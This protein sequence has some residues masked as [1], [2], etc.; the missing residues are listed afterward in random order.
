MFKVLKLSLESIKI[1]LSSDIKPQVTASSASLALTVTLPSDYETCVRTLRAAT[2]FQEDEKQPGAKFIFGVTLL[3]LCGPSA[4]R[5]QIESISSSTFEES[6][7]N[8]VAIIQ[9]YKFILYLE[10]H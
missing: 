10:L 6:K 5:W 7:R 1:F 2:T 9:I 4:Q 3:R 8:F